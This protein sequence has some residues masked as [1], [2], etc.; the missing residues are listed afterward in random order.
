MKEDQVKIHATYRLEA[1]PHFTIEGTMDLDTG[2]ADCFR[3]LKED[4]LAEIR[5]L[6]QDL[7]T[8]NKMER[9][10]RVS[11]KDAISTQDVIQSGIYQALRFFLP[12]S[13]EDAAYTGTDPSADRFLVDTIGYCYHHSFRKMIRSDWAREHSTVDTQI[14][15][16]GKNGEGYRIT[17]RSILGADG[18]VLGDHRIFPFHTGAG[19]EARRELGYAGDHQVA[20]DVRSFEEYLEAL[21]AIPGFYRT[22]HSECWQVE[23]AVRRLRILGISEK[24]IRDFKEKKIIPV[25]ETEKGSI[26][27][28]QFRAGSELL[29]KTVIWSSSV[30][31][32]LDSLGGGIPYLLFRD[33]GEIPMYAFL[34][35][36]PLIREEEHYRAEIPEGAERFVLSSIVF[37]IR[38]EDRITGTCDYEYGSIVVERTGDGPVRVG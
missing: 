34:Y 38:E 18:R 21:R 31:Y 24:E 26:R 22:Y 25:I 20:A 17:E 9:D 10:F 8:E 16:T 6:Y 1:A 2:E 23:E 37:M 28:K 12:Q 27:R 14:E 35:V 19:R 15:V 30:R 32:L 33:K 7:H 36:E 4:R 13:Y 29:N 5:V 11:V 3:P